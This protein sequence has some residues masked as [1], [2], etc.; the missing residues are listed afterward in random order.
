MVGGR[1]SNSWV[2]S[3][4]IACAVHRTNVENLLTIT[5]SHHQDCREAKNCPTSN[6]IN[7]SYPFPYPLFVDTPSYPTYSPLHFV[8]HRETLAVSTSVPTAIYPASALPHNL[9]K[10]LH[11]TPQ[12]RRTQPTSPHHR[13]DHLNSPEKKKLHLPL[14]KPFQEKT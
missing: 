6:L 4:R 5:Y 9:Q 10:N 11:L 14:L 13:I 1:V 2:L 12:S 3:I 7:H 8:F